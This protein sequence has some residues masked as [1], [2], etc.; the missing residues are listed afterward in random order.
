MNGKE[1]Q[2]PFCRSLKRTK[3]T[4]KTIFQESWGVGGASR[5]LRKLFFFCLLQ[6]KSK[7]WTI[8]REDQKK[9]TIF[10]ESWGVGGVPGVSDFFL[11]LCRENQKNNFPGVLGGCGGASRSLRKFVYFC[12]LVFLVLCRC[13]FFALYFVLFL[14]VLC[15]VFDGLCWFWFVYSFSLIYYQ[16]FTKIHQKCKIHKRRPHGGPFS[17][18]SFVWLFWDH[19]PIG[20]LCVRFSVKLFVAGGSLNFS[21]RLVSRSFNCFALA[22]SRLFVFLCGLGFYKRGRSVIFSGNRLL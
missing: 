20:L 19:S 12:F 5:S 13:V 4:K 14:V 21:C 22:F 15:S 11:V 18:A 16:H 3:K 6:R 7:K 17:F 10:Q 9:R 8:Y 2:K 1:P